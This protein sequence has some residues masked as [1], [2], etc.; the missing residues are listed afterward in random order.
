MKKRITARMY[1]VTEC[2]EPNKFHELKINNS[3]I[4]FLRSVLLSNNSFYEDKNGNWLLK[5]FLGEQY[6]QVIFI[7]FS[8]KELSYKNLQVLSLSKLIIDDSA[9]D[10]LLAEEISL[11]IRKSKA[12]RKHH[13]IEYPSHY[14]HIDGRG[15]G[16]YSRIPEQEYNFSR[17]LILLALAYAYLGAIENISNRLSECICC[18]SDNIEKLRQL[19]IEATKFKAVFLFHQPV[20]MKN[21]SLIETW[22]YLDKVFDIN[23]ASDELLEQLSSV[24]YILNLDD[25]KKRKNIEDLKIKRQEKWNMLFTMLG[26]FIGLIELFK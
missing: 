17:R 25:D 19:Y 13:F 5:F 22:K 24:H 7:D 23:S 18:Q 16:F 15:M 9:F 3:N 4:L 21:V 26:I 12:I 20:L 14:E 11:E 10:D 2:Q 6:E 1:K 8:Q